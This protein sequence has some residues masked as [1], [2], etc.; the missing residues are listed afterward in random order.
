MDVKVKI[1]FNASK[2]SFESYG[3]NRYLIYLPFPEDEEAF[4]VIVSMLSKKIGV[5]I[6]KIHYKDK[7]VMGNWV[8]QLE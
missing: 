4:D 3:G 6:P 1:R 7:D 5:P 2:E 8:F